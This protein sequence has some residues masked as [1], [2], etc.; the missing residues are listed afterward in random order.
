MA[1]I[2]AI[3]KAFHPPKPIHGLT[4]EAHAIRHWSYTHRW[5]Q[6]KK[7]ENNK[8]I[9]FKNF[10]NEKIFYPIANWNN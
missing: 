4:V 6:A 10:K 9:I 3:C 2:T 1:G 7:T 8:T 5:R